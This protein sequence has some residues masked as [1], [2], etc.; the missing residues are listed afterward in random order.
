[1]DPY[2]EV[3]HQGQVSPPFSLDY[4]HGP[5]EPE[6]APLSPEYVPEPEDPKDNLKVDLAD[7]PA[8]EESS[9]D[10]ADNEDEE[11]DDD[12][13]KEEHLAPANSSDVPIDDH[14]PSAKE[15]DLLR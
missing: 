14:V 11:D 13:E 5:E 3:A 4:V 1:M 2:E 9:E 7:Y 6:Q 10:D 15:T 12:A 8:E